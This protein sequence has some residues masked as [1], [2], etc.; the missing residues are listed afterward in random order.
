MDLDFFDNA[1]DVVLEIEINPKGAAQFEHRYNAVT[2]VHPNVGRYYQH[3]PNKWGMEC[4]VYFNSEDDLSDEFTSL[5]IYVEE[6]DRP[7]RQQWAYRTNDREF[8]WELLQKGYR[9]G[10]N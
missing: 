10:E 9:L 6:G 5:G 2:G 3:Q 1:T 7:Y 4:R 8:F